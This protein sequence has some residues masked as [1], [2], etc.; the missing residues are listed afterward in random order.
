MYFLDLSLVEIV[1]DAE[2]RRCIDFAHQVSNHTTLLWLYFGTLMI[3]LVAILQHFLLMAIPK[4][5][6]LPF[7]I[8]G[9]QTGNRLINATN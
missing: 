5:F 3:S 2:Y 7:L 4:T 6:E 8:I 1:S 9:K